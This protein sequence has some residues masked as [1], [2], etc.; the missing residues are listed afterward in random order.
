MTYRVTVAPSAARQLRKFDPDVR[1]RLQAA[2]ELLAVDPRPPAT[3][4]L[5]GGSGEWRV[6]TGNYR[7]VYEIN[8]NELV[9]LVLRMGHRREVY[10]R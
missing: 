4:R 3:T 9:I 1:R 5:V 6:R 8:D 10:D 7:I 2:I